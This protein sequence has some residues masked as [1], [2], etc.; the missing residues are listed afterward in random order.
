VVINVNTTDKNGTSL[1]EL[2]EL[3]WNTAK[4]IYQIVYPLLGLELDDEKIQATRPVIAEMLN[5]HTDNE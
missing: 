2:M 3:P 1:I 5:Q 4:G